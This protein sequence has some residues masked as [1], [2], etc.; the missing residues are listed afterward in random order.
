MFAEAKSFDIGHPTKPGQR[1]R[2][3]SLEGPEYGVYY[4]GKMKG[5]IIELPSYW[6]NLVD[7]NSI[8]VTVTP[9]GRHQ[10]LYV[11]SATSR[12]VEIRNASWFDK[13]KPEY[14]YVIYGERKDIN[15]LKVEY[16]K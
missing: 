9:L 10:N 5:H 1:L 12:R 6:C 16:K 13:R 14:Y 2:Y 7:E 8:S 15:K 11:Y 4:R 3:G